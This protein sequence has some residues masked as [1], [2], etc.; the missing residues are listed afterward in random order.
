MRMRI[1]TE[2]RIRRVLTLE[3]RNTLRTLRQQARATRRER[4]QVKPE[5]R[6]KRRQERSRPYRTGATA[7]AHFFDDAKTNGVLGCNSLRPYLI[8]NGA[9]QTKLGWLFLSEVP[10]ERIEHFISAQAPHLIPSS[11]TH[12]VNFAHDKPLFS[13]V[14]AVYQESK[15]S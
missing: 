9:G 7:S 12:R 8:L 2:V 6:Q 4:L 3:Q 1:L 11:L 10:T 5:E 14:A 13:D 15:L